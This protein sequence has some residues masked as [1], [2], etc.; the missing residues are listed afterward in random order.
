MIFVENLQSL[1]FSSDELRSFFRNGEALAMAPHALT[2]FQFQQHLR[3]RCII[4]LLSRTSSKLL[5]VNLK[6]KL[7]ST[8]NNGEVTSKLL[9]PL[10]G[11]HIRGSF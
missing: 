8:G 2:T 11:S 7:L 10:H 1:F 4:Q 6:G 3:D 5:C 9:L